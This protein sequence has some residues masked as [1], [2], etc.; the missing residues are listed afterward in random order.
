[1]R[2]GSLLALLAGAAHALKLPAP[3]SSALSRRA[4]LGGCAAAVLAPSSAWSDDPLAE[5]PPK[6]KQAYLQYLPQLQLDGDYFAFVLEPLVAQPGRWD[7]I[8]ALVTSTDIGS[9]ASVSRLE[10]EFITPMRQ[11][12]LSF[13]PDLGGEEMQD[14]IDKFQRNIY[15]LAAAA[16][17]G[18]TIGNTAGPSKAELKAVEDSFDG[19]RQA[20]NAFFAEVNK[21]VGAKRLE[22]V[23]K[24]GTKGGY[25]RSEKLHAPPVAKGPPP[26]LCCH[27]GLSARL[28]AS[29]AQ[30]APAH[31]GAP[32]PQLGGPPRPQELTSACSQEETSP[33]LPPPGTRSCSRTRRS[34]AT[35]AARRSR[36]SGAT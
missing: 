2:A 36:G 13:P 10:R 25:T 8:S 31:P 3:A 16:R 12:A 33:L 35:A 19:G 6:A 29:R 1:M 32:P 20:M 11:I 24:G 30:G 21:G 7:Q 27:T 28:A 14:A 15:S 9:A 17:K 18:S 22:A 23:P 34:A 5:L 26:G 4:V